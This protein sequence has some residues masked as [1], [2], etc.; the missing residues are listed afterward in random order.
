[1]WLLT[2]V[3]PPPDRRPRLRYI[4]AVGIAATDIIR[5]ASDAQLAPLAAGGDMCPVT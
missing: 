4:A 3:R 2:P 1:M 5:L